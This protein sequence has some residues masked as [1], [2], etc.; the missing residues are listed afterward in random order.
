MIK[1]AKIIEIGKGKKKVEFFHLGIYDLLKVELGYRYTV[2]NKKGYF[3][4][5]IDGVLKVVQ[6]IDIKDDFKNHIKNNFETIKIEGA[7]SY[8]DF[9]EEYFKQSPIKNGNYIRTYLNEN[10]ILSKEN[11]HQILLKTD[12]DYANEF[13]KN[14]M[15]DFLNRQEFTKTIEKIGNYE[16]GMPIY[17][18]KVSSNTY[19]LVI[20][21]DY[22]R[23]GTTTTFDLF[24][25]S[26]KSEKDL[27]CKQDDDI[28]TIKLGFNLKRDFKLF[29]NEINLSK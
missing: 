20:M 5:E 10:F 27:L 23:K 9:I 13:L 26:A 16:K 18:K 8:H 29:E 24:K 19:L 7:I 22:K 14:E 15:I 28:K 11:K 4:K 21:F 17:Y 6:F 1:I 12:C 25:V 2:I 3:L